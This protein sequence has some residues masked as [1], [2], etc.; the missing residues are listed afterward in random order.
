MFSIHTH[1]HFSLRLLGLAL[2]AAL[3]ASCTVSLSPEPALAAP[4]SG[5][6]EPGGTVTCTYAYTGSEQTL[7][8][9]AGVTSVHVEAAGGAGGAGNTLGTWHN[10]AGGLG[11]SVSGDVPVTPGSTLYVE[12]GGAG[13]GGTPSGPGAGG[14][15]GG[16]GGGDGTSSGGGGGGGGATDLRTVSCGSGSCPG[17]SA[18]LGSRLLVAAGGGGGGAAGCRSG[19]GG[20]AGSPGV[21]GTE[22]G[23]NGGTELPTSGHGGGAGGQSAG[24]AGGQPGSTTPCA[25]TALAG[26][27]GAEGQG[28]SGG[29]DDAVSGGGGGAGYYGGGGGATASTASAC[30]AGGGGGGSDYAANAVSNAS[31]GTAAVGTAPSVTI[32]FPAPPGLSQT[33]YVAAKGHDTLT[34]AQNSQADEFATVQ[35]ALQ[36]AG[37]GDVIVLAPSPI[38]GYPGIGTVNHNLTIEAAPGADVTNLLIN[39]AGGETTTPRELTVAAGATVTVRGILLGCNINND[40]CLLPNVINHGTLILDHSYVAGATHAPGV[41]NLGAGSAPA[42]L[43]VLDST[44]SNNTNDG[45]TPYAQVLP[46]AA[47]IVNQGS[48]GTQVTIANS[49]IAYNQDTVPGNAGGIYTSVTDGAV[50]LINATV[51]FNQA[52]GADSAGGI[53]AKV[54]QGASAHPVHASNTIVANNTSD[55]GSA[56]CLGQIVDGPGGHNLLGDPTGCAG[57]TDAQS[58]DMVGVGDAGL[59]GLQGYGGPTDT[60][61]L[62][63]ESP[64]IGAGDPGTCEAPPISDTDQ[65]GEPRNSASRTRC[66]I[67]AYD[68]GGGPASQDSIVYVGPSGSDSVSCHDSS[69]SNPLRTIQH[70]LACDFDTVELAPSGSTPYPGIGTLPYSVTIEAEPGADARSVKIDVSQPS[71]NQ[72]TGAAGGELVVPSSISAVLKGVTLD[73]VSH[74]CL[75]AAVTNHGIL[76]MQGDT[77]TGQGQAVGVHNDSSAGSIPARLT[78]LDS[79]ITGN[80][81]A[82]GFYDTGSG[83]LDSTRDETGQ[84]SGG[85]PPDLTI[86]NSTIA[87]NTGRVAGSAGGLYAEYNYGT[88]LIN[89]TIADNQGYTAGGVYSGAGAAGTA[90]GV[91]ASNTV[92]AGNQALIQTGDADCQG[93]ITDGPGAHNL[94]GDSTGCGGLIDGQNGDQVGVPKPG[95][96]AGPADNGGSTDTVALQSGSPAIAHGDAPTCRALPI[97]NLDQRG[98]ARHV[99]AGTCDVGAYE[100]RTTAPGRTLTVT[101]SGT[102]S[103]TVASSPAGIDCGSTC[104][105]S[106]EDGTSVTLTATPVT[107]ST[108]TGWT[109]CDSVDTDKCTVVMDSDRTVTA[110]FSLPGGSV[111]GTGNGSPTVSLAPTVE[112]SCQAAIIGQTSATLVATVNPGGEAT[113]AQFQYGRTA[114]YGSTTT[115]QSVG[116]DTRDHGVSASIG[117]LQPGV[118]FHCRVLATNAT[119]TTYG[120]DQTFTTTPANPRGKARTSSRLRV[121]S[122]QATASRQGSAVTLT[123][124]GTIN[125]HAD[126]QRITVTVRLPTPG[127]PAQV[128]V[129]TARAR[130][131]AR[132]WRVRFTLVIDGSESNRSWSFRASYAGDRTLLPATVT[133]GISVAIRPR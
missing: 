99:A 102:G 113:T 103:G 93:R 26:S 129:F 7:S 1:L 89:D 43:T 41:E 108:F 64:V 17:N 39:L 34:C 88:T 125:G 95:L 53:M 36:C 9:P 132:H 44:I 6:T 45:L 61:G 84:Q 3:V 35:R 15:N 52:T 133:G 97:S 10:G 70:A 51:A 14:W 68:T 90:A 101:K 114:A 107:G 23:C 46:Y 94:L 11:G 38:G 120:P 24:G 16:A 28:G 25:G 29:G 40:D 77:V 66:D 87:G 69:P 56:D 20:A 121:R 110:T 31:T 80:T 106:D 50:T 124:S 63:P 73:C 109:G 86:A 33:Y 123:L 37:D 82:L 112:Q 27:D 60:V 59:S 104:S 54:S 57:L 128:R 49:T 119:G 130:V 21:D 2:I 18:S 47:G 81:N 79:T 115:T 62:L 75:H 126:G 32:T 12:V 72:S 117:A 55:T 5:C 83:G 74:Q 65:R 111:N 58:G 13:A 48:N 78:V 67:G 8:V 96:A 4:P 131:T 127:R 92:I 91:T 105:S 30:G 118:T 98:V 100:Y 85:P 22:F 19:A 42:K 116:S 76:R 122:I 71:D